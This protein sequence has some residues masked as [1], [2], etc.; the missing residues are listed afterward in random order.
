MTSNSEPVS[1]DK[2]GPDTSRK[3]DEQAS[4][5]KPDIPPTTSVPQLPPSE[6]HRQITNK[7]EKNWWDKIKPFIE[8]AGITLLAVYTIYTIK[9]YHANKEAAD[10]AKNAA[11]TAD[12]TLR[13]IQKG[14]TD[15]HDLAVAAG[16][17]ASQA[18]NQANAARVSADAAKS[19]ADT[20]ARSL[21]LSDRPWVKVTDLKPRGAHTILSLSFQDL[22]L[23]H[24]KGIPAGLKYQVTFNYEVHLKIIGRSPALNITVWPELYL[25]PWGNSPYSSLVTAEENRVCDEF[26]KSKKEINNA[27]TVA[28][29]DETPVIYQGA[30]SMVYE[31]SKNRFSDAPGDYILPVLIGC[32]DYQFQSS[33][34]HHQTRFVYE[35][36]HAQE[37]RTRFFLVGKDVSADDLM[38]IRN[39]SDDYAY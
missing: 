33:D 31:G 11:A 5:T 36:F 14:G 21:E 28:F 37:P 34:R 29:P 6:G 22:T 10:A 30:A 1:K 9:M 12:A 19:A 15:T 4:Q 32:V 18:V 16:K 3:S 17:Q 7:P 20:A 8:I 38:V 24:L 26:S 35:T 39:E 13:E 25:A 2:P 27:G 23:G